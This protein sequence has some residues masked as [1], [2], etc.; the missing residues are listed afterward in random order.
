MTQG[1]RTAL[2]LAALALLLC[3]AA[4]WGWTAATKPLPAKVDSAVCVDTA[5][6]K[7]DKVYPQQVTVSVLN[8][9]QREG[10]AGRTMQLFK[11]RGFAE[12]TAGNAASAKVRV[13]EIWTED[14][15]SPAV[16][17]VA[18]VLG[19]GVEVKQQTSPGAGVTVVVGDE[20]RKLAKGRASVTSTEDTE[21]CSPPVE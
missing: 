15:D 19:K 3:L 14:P 17:L 21:I 8:G 20:F 2:T 5:V 11:D 12:G 18:S 1:V 13:A 7:G 9:G 4:L 16:R 10:L 6:S